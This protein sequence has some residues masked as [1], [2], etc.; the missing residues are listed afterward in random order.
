MIKLFA[1]DVDGTL[2][3]GGVY[4]DGKDN[5]YKKF[6]T[7]DG[8]GIASLLKTGIKVV[9][10]SGRYSDATK[11]RANELKITAC[12]NGTDNKLADLKKIASDFDL[13]PEE[14]AYA[15]DDIPDLECIL[16]A[17]LGI[18]T[19]NAV[20]EVIKHAK[21]CTSKPGGYGAIR[22]CADYIQKINGDSQ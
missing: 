11:A 15:G 3:D 9:F 4:I 1:L 17:G 16:W 5:E 8:Y 2:T 13:L 18:A 14:I 20:A 19:K 22:E 12:I 6:N 7:Q 21:W 10:I